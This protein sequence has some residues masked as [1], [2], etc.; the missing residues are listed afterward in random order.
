MMYTASACN[1]GVIGKRDF[2]E[3]FQLHS[4]ETSRRTKNIVKGLSYD[5]FLQKQSR[6]GFVSHSRQ[7]QTTVLLDNIDAKIIVYLYSG[8]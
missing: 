3:M 6:S 2:L 8:S 1:L 4:L 5:A 7:C